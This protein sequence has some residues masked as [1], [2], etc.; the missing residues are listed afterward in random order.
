LGGRA[1]ESREMTEGYSIYKPG[2]RASF[3]DCRR[4][5]RPSG[6]NETL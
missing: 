5:V 2:K 4:P 6:R 1:V 3:F